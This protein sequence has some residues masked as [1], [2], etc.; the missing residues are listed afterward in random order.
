MLTRRGVT[1]IELLMTIVIG[2]IAMFSLAP[3]LIAE[4]QLFRKGK[5]QTEAQRDAQMALRAMAWSGRES[6]GCNITI[7]P[8]SIRVEFTKTDE[9]GIPVRECF[10]GRPTS[11]TGNGQLSFNPGCE[12]FGGGVVLIDG[13]RSR[14]VEMTATE[15][16][17]NRLLNLHVL[18]SHRLRTTDPYQEDEILDTELFLR[19]GT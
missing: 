8:N 7:A 1:L 4:G 6:N 10:D 18:V 15:T 3:V 2:S 11:Q 12:V 16:I 14:L 9:S 13:V 5:R 17:N 19:N